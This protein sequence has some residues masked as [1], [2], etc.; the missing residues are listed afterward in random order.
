[1]F[2]HKNFATGGFFPGRVTT[3]SIANLGSFEIEVI[4]EPVQPTGGGGGYYQP[5]KKDK[6]KIRIRVSS[7][8]RKWEYESIVNSLTAKVVAKLSGI[9][10][11]APEVQ[12]K[13]VTVS[14]KI[15]PTIKVDKK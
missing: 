11:K 3:R 5:S 8:G 13:S 6:Y 12:V 1:M 4:I 15:T 9:T 10:L 14:Q 7:K 2:D